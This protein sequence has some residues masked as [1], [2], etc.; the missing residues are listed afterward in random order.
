[1]N[2]AL[3][4]SGGC[5]KR[6]GSTVPKQYHLARLRMVIEYVLEAASN[7]QSIDLVVVAATHPCD[8]LNRLSPRYRFDVT[9]AGA[10]RNDT[11]KNGLD[12]LHARGCEKVI[13]LDAV[14][15]MVTSAVID[16]CM[17]LLDEGYDAV[18]TAQPITDSLGSYDLHEVDRSR[19]YLMQS[20]EAFRFPLLYEHFDKESP[21]TEVVQQLP[22]GTPCYLNFDFQNNIKLTYPWD[23]AYI[24]LAL[25]HRTAEA[26]SDFWHMPGHLPPKK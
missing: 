21:L 8:R 5:G 15:P 25:W 10:R 3:I 23:L 14:R 13:V 4:L 18:T 1:M 9:E 11:L 22:A 12:Y 7:A 20:P 2:A 6:F 26:I 16:R 24:E 19:Y 17:Q